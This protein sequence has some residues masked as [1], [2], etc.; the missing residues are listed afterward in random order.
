MRMILREIAR[1]VWNLI[2]FGLVL[3]LIALMSGYVM[4][5]LE[6][7]DRKEVEY[8]KQI[9]NE[10]LR[11]SIYKQNTAYCS[12]HKHFDFCREVLLLD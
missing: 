9:K 1:M 12:G 5:L 2:L 4:G 7:F 6:E 3:A 11:N 8:R 10:Y